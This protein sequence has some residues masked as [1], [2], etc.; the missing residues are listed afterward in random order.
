ME[1]RVIRSSHLALRFYTHQGWTEQSLRPYLTKG[2]IE[3]VDSAPVD[4]SDPWSAHFEYWRLKC[5]DMTSSFDV[6]KLAED[7]R[8]FDYNGKE[9]FGEDAKKYLHGLNW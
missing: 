2:D 1:K 7:C 9:L 6:D 8:V 5:Q 3:V 4:R